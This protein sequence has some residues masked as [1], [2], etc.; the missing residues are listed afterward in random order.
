MGIK[1]K[2]ILHGFL[3]EVT[4]R[5]DLAP[6]LGELSPQ[7]TERARFLPLPLCLRLHH[8]PGDV[9]AVQILALDDQLIVGGVEGLQHN[10]VAPL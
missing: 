10:A 7:V 4:R 1:K 9:Q 3:F 8:A 6:P 2:A 5:S